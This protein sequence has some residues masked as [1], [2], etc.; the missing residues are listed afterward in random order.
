L[1]K[2][3]GFG[4]DDLDLI[5]EVYT[6]LLNFPVPTLGEAYH[7]G[8]VILVWDVVN[9]ET[10]HPERGHNVVCHEFAHK[11][12]MLDGIA[13]GLQFIT[14]PEEYQRWSEVSSNIVFRAM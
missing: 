8:P 2:G 4:C 10:R 3:N 12:N 6:T 11:L 14:T 9:I 7:R 13:D 5:Y 1:T